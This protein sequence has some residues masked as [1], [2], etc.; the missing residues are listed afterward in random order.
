MARSKTDDS[1]EALHKPAHI[2]VDYKGHTGPDHRHSH[3]GEHAI[4]GA[5]GDPLLIAPGLNKLDAAFADAVSG[6]KTITVTDGNLRGY[7]SPAALRDLAERTQSPDALEHILELEKAKPQSGPA[8]GRRSADLTELLE[9]RVEMF[10]RRKVINL[11]GITQ[12]AQAQADIAPQEKFRRAER[13][14]VAV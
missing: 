14:N 3:D 1:T 9:R 11:A 8:G 6:T 7:E 2:W 5:S 4:V 12:Q 13:A 10:G